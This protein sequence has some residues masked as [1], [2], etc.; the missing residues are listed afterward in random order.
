MQQ[1]GSIIQRGVRCPR[2][3]GKCYREDPTNPKSDVWCLL[4]GEW[5]CP[6]GFEPKPYLVRLEDSVNGHNWKIDEHGDIIDFIDLKI[7]ALV[8]EGNPLTVSH[9][10]KKV[11]CSNGD[12]RMTLERLTRIGKVRRFNYGPMDRWVAYQQL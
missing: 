10:A 12:A 5:I 1:S 3:K 7:E 8:D 2:C 11:H 4:C 6:P 9:V